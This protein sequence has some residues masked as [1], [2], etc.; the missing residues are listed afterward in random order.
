MSSAKGLQETEPF[1]VKFQ[2][3]PGHITVFLITFTF[4]VH[5]I[6]GHTYSYGWK[7]DKMTES[8]ERQVLEAL[9]SQEN[10]S[11]W[12]NDRGVG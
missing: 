8:D 4:I 1:R 2:L 5:Q 3:K 9:S 10:F 7:L 12:K 11:F 6:R